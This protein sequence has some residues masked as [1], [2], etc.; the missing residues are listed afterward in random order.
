MKRVPIILLKK[1]RF[2]L[3]KQTKK[4]NNN[5]KEENK[6]IEIRAMR[7]TPLPKANW[8][9]KGKSFFFKCENRVQSLNICHNH[10]KPEQFK[11]ADGQG[12]NF[13]LLSYAMEKEQIMSLVTVWGGAM[14]CISWHFVT[15]WVVGIFCTRRCSR[16]QCEVEP[17][18]L[19][20]RHHCAHYQLQKPV[21]HSSA[22]F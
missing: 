21:A 7:H 18:Q 10:Q 22:I 3:N 12:I 11:N 17:S 8:W 1:I 2:L 15:V 14:P 20:P 19:M 13:C 16:L 9:L 5:N 4:C 6:A